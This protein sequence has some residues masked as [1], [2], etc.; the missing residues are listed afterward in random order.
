MLKSYVSLF[1]AKTWTIISLN[2][3]IHITLFSS[4]PSQSIQ[5]VH[6]EDDVDDSDF[7]EMSGECTT[8]LDSDLGHTDHGY[9]ADTEYTEEENN[10]GM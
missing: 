10:N 1:C 5:H 2:Q 3:A 8:S 7:S 4:P 6:I 9:E